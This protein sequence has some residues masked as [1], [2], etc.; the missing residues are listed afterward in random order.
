MIKLLQFSV[1]SLVILFSTGCVQNQAFHVISVYEG[2]TPSGVDGRPW[3]AKCG[4]DLK[5]FIQKG[6]DKRSTTATNKVEKNFSL[7]CFPREEIEKEVIVNISDDTNAI[8]IAL[9]AYDKTLWKV[10]LKNDVKISKVIL[11]GYNPQRVNG[12]PEDTPIEAYTYL[13]SKCGHCS[14]HK[15]ALPTIREFPPKELNEIAGIDVTSFQAEYTGNEFSIFPGMMKYGDILGFPK[16][17]LSPKHVYSAIEKYGP[18][19]VI[20]KIFGSETYKEE[21]LLGVRNGDN[22]WLTAAQLMVRIEY[23][24]KWKEFEYSLVEAL[25]KAPKKA[26]Q[27]L[28]YYNDGSELCNFDPEIELTDDLSKYLDNLDI[29][30]A[31][32]LRKLRQPRQIIDLYYKCQ[33][34]IEK[35]RIQ[36]KER[37]LFIK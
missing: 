15:F 4:I 13:P 19:V 7:H 28:N 1:F 17:N 36:I 21:F 6:G 5:H 16:Q 12:I 29:A 30:L 24:R 26:I 14:N 9:I 2:K 3:W 27:S 8:V 34:G 18:V 25:P 37:S 31:G 35:T 20:D 32:E 23:F 22:D 11:G 10:K 33:K